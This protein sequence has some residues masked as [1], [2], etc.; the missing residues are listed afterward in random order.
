[1]KALEFLPVALS[2]R[3]IRDLRPEAGKKCPIVAPRE[4]RLLR[5][6]YIYIYMC[7]YVCACFKQWDAMRIEMCVE[8]ER[9]RERLLSTPYFL[10]HRGKKTFT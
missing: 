3:D 8:R 1:M 10:S 7:V 9:E 6:I 5:N 4:G 2:T